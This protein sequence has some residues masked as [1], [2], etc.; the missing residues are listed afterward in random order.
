MSITIESAHVPDAVY[1]CIQTCCCLCV[2]ASVD[3]QRFFVGV[4]VKCVLSVVDTWISVNLEGA[5]TQREQRLY[6]KF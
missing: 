5:L 4:G 1:G 6:T 3:S 2:H